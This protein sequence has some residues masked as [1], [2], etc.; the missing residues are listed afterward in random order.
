MDEIIR[1]LIDLHKEGERQG[2]GGERETELALELAHLNRSLPL[3]IADI[4]CGSGASV[5]VLA[6]MPKVRV[7]AVDISEEFLEELMRRAAAKG[8]SHKIS[9]LRC[10]MEELPFNREEFDVIWS[11]GA[12]YNMGFKNGVTSWR[13][14]LKTGGLLAVSE[15]TWLTDDPPAELRQYWEAQYKEIG[16]ASSKMKILEQSG[17]EPIGYF[18]LPENC[19]LE[20]YYYPLQ[21]RFAGFL[22]RNGNRPEAQALVEEHRQEMEWY[23]KYKDYYGYG[24]YLAKKIAF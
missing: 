9:P 6:K 2:P 15:V 22:E 17:Y 4:G 7:T 1:L 12:I 14:F 8:V 10:S 5:L 11:E 24:F 19:W 21:R 16:T 13:K 3:N 18:V 23:E 20:N